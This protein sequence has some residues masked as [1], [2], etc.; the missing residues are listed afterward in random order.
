M[1][2]ANLRAMKPHDIPSF[3]TPSSFVTFRLARLQCGLN[4]QGTAL[5]KSK[6]GLSLVEW[7]LIQTLRMIKNA[8]LTEIADHVQ[9]DK[10]QL[11]RKIK[12]MVENG[13]LTTKT[14]KRDQRIQ[15][16]TLTSKAEQLSAQ[17]MPIMETRQRRLL[18]DVSAEDLEVFYGVIDK[19]E[20][21]SKIRSDA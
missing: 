18:A 2:S 19:I 20:A 7:R 3:Q 10:G 8:S 14:D 6:S 11:S 9:M 13:L 4:A 17:M 16:L 15:H 5:L 12:A 21:A 1:V